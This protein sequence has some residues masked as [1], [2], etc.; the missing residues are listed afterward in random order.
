[1]L[2][3]N[4]QYNNVA[5]GDAEATMS[6]IRAKVSQL[7]GA[8]IPAK[9]LEYTFDDD[10]DTGYITIVVDWAGIEASVA[11]NRI[12]KLAEKIADTPAIILER[13]VFK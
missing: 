13:F 11:A 2:K 6:Q 1:M 10:A 12:D 5:I 3:A 4:L 8:V 7:Q 9:G